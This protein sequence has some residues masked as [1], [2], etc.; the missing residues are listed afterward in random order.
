MLPCRAI[1]N[2]QK[3]RLAVVLDDNLF[4]LV[5]V[6]PR[7]QATGTVRLAMS[8]RNQEVR[9]LRATPEAERSQHAGA[10]NSAR[11][12]YQQ[13]VRVARVH[14]PRVVQTACQV[15]R[16]APV[17]ER[18]CSQRVRSGRWLGSAA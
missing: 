6:N 1:A 11:C 17:A 18:C 5:E 4:L 8:L 14:R 15:R 12:R 10:P 16:S 3:L 9:A 13:L 2:Q 7:N